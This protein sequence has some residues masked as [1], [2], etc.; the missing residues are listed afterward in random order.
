MR[1]SRVERLFDPETPNSCLIWRSK[2]VAR[3]NLA[4]PLWRPRKHVPCFVACWTP[5]TF[6]D[7]IWPANFGFF[8]FHY[9]LHFLVVFV[10]FPFSVVVFVFFSCFILVSVHFP[11]VKTA[12]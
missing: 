9:A 5:K 11:F 8:V 7:G 12:R 4:H 3:S 6:L 10:V 1:L 2:P